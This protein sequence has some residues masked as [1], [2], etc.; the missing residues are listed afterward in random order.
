MRVRRTHPFLHL[1]GRFRDPTVER[2]AVSFYNI[3]DALDVICPT[4]NLSKDFERGFV[5]VKTE[6]LGFMSGLMQEGI[7]RGIIAP[8]PVQYLMFAGWAT[9]AGAMRMDTSMFGEPFD[10]EAALEYLT[11][12]IIKG[13]MNAQGRPSA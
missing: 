8:Q 5:Q 3:F 12:Y 2:S 7:D 10:E 13:L 6:M 1:L 4:L 9:M 11:D